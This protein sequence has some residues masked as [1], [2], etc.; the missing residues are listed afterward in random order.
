MKI[1]IAPDSFKESLEALDVCHA[2]QSGF[3]QVFPDADYKLLPMA[4]GGEGTS[5]VLS[6]VLGGY[7]KEVVVN[8]PLMRPISAKY[9][10]LPDATAVIEIS[11]ACGLHL[12]TIAERNP[13]VASSYGVGELITDALNEGVKRIIIGL[14]GS[15]TNDA[16]LGMLTALGMT[17]HDSDDNT[18]AQGGGA[19]TNLQRLDATSFHASLLE[20]VFEVACD[21]TN[22]LCGELGASA[23]FGPQKGASSQQVNTLDQALSHFASVCEQ[24]GYQD[25][26]EI[27]GAGAAGGLGY[28][29]MSFCQA[30]LKSGFDTIAEVANLSQ[31]IADADLVITGEGKLDAQSA[32]GKVAGGVSHLAKL[33]HIPVIAICGSVDSLEPTQTSQFDVIMPS[34][35]KLDTIDNVFKS[36][37]R[38]IETTATNI[39]AAI[40]LGQSIK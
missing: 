4:D 33:S 8:D 30:E 23:I 15:A 34:I 35:Q 32:M 5:T 12:L 17:F 29:L 1:L 13:V 11:Q 9:L 36:A 2:I 37:Y 22:P 39:A 38:N 31:H 6:Y 18:L 7:W 16:G 19:L 21:V 26:Q 10:L 14:G 25:Y 40:K 28:A 20:T 27:A 3:S 24:H